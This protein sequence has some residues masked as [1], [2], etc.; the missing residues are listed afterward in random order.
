MRCPWTWLLSDMKALSEFHF[1]STIR[2]R[3]LLVE[4]YVVD[5]EKGYRDRHV[6][7]NLDGNK[8]MTMDGDILT[9]HKGFRWDL[10]SPSFRFRNWWLGTPSGP[11]EA[12]GSAIHDATR[13]V[14]RLGCVPFDRKDTDDFFW[15]ALGLSG[16]R[17]KRTYHFVVASPLGTL[18]IKLSKKPLDCQCLKHEN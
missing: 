18:F 15:D 8:F 9:L 16:S 14:M 6:F 5:L 1:T 3:G 10:C 4:D 13:R 17:V 11:R 7:A 2:S 12:P